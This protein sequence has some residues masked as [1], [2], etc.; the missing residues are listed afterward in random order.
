MYGDDVKKQQLVVTLKGKPMSQ[1]MLI[2]PN[3]SKPFEIQCDACGD[4]LGA[5]LLQDNHAIAYK[6]YKLHEQERLLGIYEKEII[7]IIHALSFW[8]HYLLSTPFI[9]Q[10]DYQNI[11]YF[12]TQTKI[13]DKQ[14]QWANFLS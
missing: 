5:I 7:A 13:S 3:L 12:M 9:I 8:K 11:K 14:M 4:C 10:T 1:P 2:L 6:S